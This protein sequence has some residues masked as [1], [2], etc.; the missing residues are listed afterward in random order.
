MK[1]RGAGRL[2]NSNNLLLRVP[3]PSSAW[4]GFSAGDR[5]FRVRKN[6]GLFAFLRAV[7]L[8]LDLNHFPFAV[9]VVAK[10]LPKP[11]LGARHQFPLHRIT[12]NV[13]QLLHEFA[14][15]PNVEVVVARLPKRILLHARLAGGHT[16][17]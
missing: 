4:A 13:S 3:R 7:P 5:T 9:S 6:P 10:L 16:L 14:F 11:I 12:M 2:G 8:R 15:A 17:F 1:Y